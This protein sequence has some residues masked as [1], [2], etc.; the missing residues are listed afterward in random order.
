M[1]SPGEN[2]AS[3]KFRVSAW[4]VGHIGVTSIQN[5]FITKGYQWRKMR[6]EGSAGL[7]IEFRSCWGA[8]DYT[9]RPHE[10]DAVSGVKNNKSVTYIWTDLLFCNLFLLILNTHPPEVSNT[11]RFDENQFA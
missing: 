1:V 9:S 4:L 10:T 7:P 5:I 3:V 8:E 11:I 6:W 2:E